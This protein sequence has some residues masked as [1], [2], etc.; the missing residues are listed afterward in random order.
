MSI[1]KEIKELIQN[2]KYQDAINILD[3]VDMNAE[4]YILKGNA[5]YELSKFDI[6][7]EMYKKSLELDKNSARAYNNLGNAKANLEDLD[8]AL[9]C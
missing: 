7:V 5:Y 8:G 3:S 2:K 1:E 9:E 6:A 4:L